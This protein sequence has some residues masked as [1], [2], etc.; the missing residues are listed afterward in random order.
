MIN[1]WPAFY[2]GILIP[3]RDPNVITPGL[4]LSHFELLAHI[5]HNDLYW[6]GMQWAVKRED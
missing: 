3:E 2:F 5:Y 6:N 4:Q 1:T